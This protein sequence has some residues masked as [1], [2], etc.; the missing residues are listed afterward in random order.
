MLRVFALENILIGAIAALL[1]LIM[2]QIAGYA[3]VRFVFELDY[4][5]FIGS[6]LLLVV[7]TIALV[8]GVGLLASRSI[9]RQKPIVFLR[10]QSGE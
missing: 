10:E 5:P 3:L 6:S 9:L 7:G 1:A 8:T 4:L 2:S